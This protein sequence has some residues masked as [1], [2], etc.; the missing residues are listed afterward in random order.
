[1]N[2]RHNVRF[3]PVEETDCDATGNI[4]AGTVVDTG[5]SS[6]FSPCI[7]LTVI[8]IAHPYDF[9][10]YL[11]SHPG[12]KG[13]SRPVHY[14]VLYDENNFNSDTLQTATYHLCYLYCRR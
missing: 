5:I 7:V 14:C 9:D 10:F 2:K 6:P 3:V 4:P 1:M 13:T 11:N 12:L 8:D